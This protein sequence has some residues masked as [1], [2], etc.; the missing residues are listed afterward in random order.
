MSET[1]RC[2]LL[3]IEGTITSIAFVREILFPYAKSRLASFLRARGH[4]PEVR[5]WLDR[6]RD[7]VMRVE[8]ARPTDN[9]LARVLARWIDE[10]RKEPGLKGIQGLIWEEGYRAGAFAPALYE[11]VLPAL[12]QWRAKGLDLALYSSGS[13][14]AQRLL[15]AHTAQGDLTH[16]FSH[17]FDT[18]VGA[19]TEAGS[20]RRIVEHWNQRPEA[21]LFLSDIEAELDAA[22]TAGLATTHIV[23]SG[24]KAGIRHPVS[25]DLSS[26]EIPPVRA[27]AAGRGRPR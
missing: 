23:R 24:G 12:M 9:E 13:E 1:I 15:V 18:R 10:D 16:L 19:K 11:D 3:D 7:A 26:L 14:R 25:G 17:F 5:H 8:G 6:S 27:S 21:V 20:Y 2:V 22:R 4:E